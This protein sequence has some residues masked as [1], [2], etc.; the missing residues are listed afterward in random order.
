MGMGTAAYSNYV[1]EY[2]E[3][4]KLCP[5][6]IE[7]IEKESFFESIGWL[8]IA[9]L[10]YCPVCFKEDICDA[11]LEEYE[12]DSSVT[13][14]VAWSQAETYL[15]RYKK[16]IQKL[17]KDFQDVTGLGLELWT[18]N[19]A[20]GDRDV[21]PRD[22]D[23]CIFVVDGMTQLTPA[24]KKFKNIVFERSWIQYRLDDLWN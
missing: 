23:G 17:I 11:I 4:K 2:E 22:K 12:E 21:N 14:K 20:D 1:I 24:G 15:K 7:S 3:L 19:R 13:Y 9:K 6:A 18:Y 5:T 8:G 10:T 16:H